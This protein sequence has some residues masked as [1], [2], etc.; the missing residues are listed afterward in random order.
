[1]SSDH[2][3]ASVISI[4]EVQLIGSILDDDLASL[5]SPIAMPRP[6][7][8]LSQPF[9]RSISAPPQ[10]SQDGS[11]LVYVNGETISPEDP[12]LSPAY[13][14]YYYSQ[15]PIDPRLP[16]PLLDYS[17]WGSSLHQPDAFKHMRLPTMQ[18]GKRPGMSPL[19]K[20]S[21]WAR[22]KSF[23]ASMIQHDFPRTPSP[24]FPAEW[25][26]TDTKA[27]DGSIF[28]TA[29]RGVASRDQ[30]LHRSASATIDHLQAN[31][32]SFHIGALP[33]PKQYDLSSHLQGMREPDASRYGSSLPQSR[34]YW[35]T[36][37]A[38]QPIYH[39]DYTNPSHLT[40]H[41]SNTNGHKPRKTNQDTDGSSRMAILHEL[42][43][44]KHHH[45]IRLSDVV[46][47]ELVA[48]LATDQNGSRFIQL[49]LEQAS[50]GQLQDMFEQ[51]EQDTIR[52]SVDVFA[53]YVIQK[54]FEYGRPSHRRGLAGRMRGAI[55]PLSMQ[56]YGCRVV[57][58]ALEVIDLDQ[59]LQFVNEL[60][61]HVDKCVKDQN[62]NHVI[63]KCIEVLPH[64]AITFV[65]D[66]FVGNVYT[67]STHAYGCRVIQ[68]LLGHCQDP[69]R[70]EQLLSEIMSRISDLILDQ[71]G[72]YVIQNI[73]ERGPA[74]HRDAII[75]HVK[76]QVCEL[77]RHKFASNV[78]EKCFAFGSEQDREAL[79]QET[80]GELP[81]Q[82]GDSNVSLCPLILMV[83]D[84]FGNY[85]IQKILSVV[86]SDHRDRLV[87][88]MRAKIPN[89]R[90]IAFGKHIVA[91][92][93]RLTGV[94]I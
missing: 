36:H 71:F 43:S 56:M 47:Q 68:R 35:N 76:G 91:T 70:K 19:D 5:P 62:G 67:F 8:S 30:S 88:T 80:C 13:Y 42:H 12:R 44:S 63:Q 10:L 57:Q 38:M 82:K 61:G 34:Q 14:A 52:L 60:R 2:G 6:R 54:F 55:L 53:N 26:G 25:H 90:K 31:I 4:P 46:S 20:G 87:N 85:V 3:R 17:S 50:K 18:A 39:G 74:S 33:H 69:F 21:T 75:A 86:N 16:P 77:S 64:D 48:L 41:P 28:M 22:E 73:I 23:G 24:V 65:I 89:L 72:N 51:L 83:K 92:V 79:V 7:A 40:R 49:Q 58:K 59:Q 84:P 1:M 11:P 37:G 78:V 15:R 94:V 29:P 32:D 9:A 66:A 45:H 27:Q 81:S 93:A